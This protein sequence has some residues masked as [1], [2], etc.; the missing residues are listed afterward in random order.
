MLAFVNVMVLIVEGFIPRT[1]GAV[2]SNENISKA[3]RINNDIELN[4]D[5]VVTTMSLK[6]GDNIVLCRCWRSSKFPYCDG[7][8]IQHNKENQDNIGPCI[9][10]VN[11][12]EP[13]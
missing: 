6:P 8:H 4:K 13:N 2:N 9:V 1:I 12:E 11:K 3:S 7:K 10:L 5:K